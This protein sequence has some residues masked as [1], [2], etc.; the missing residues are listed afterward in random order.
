MQINSLGTLRKNRLKNCPFK[1]DRKLQEA[2]GRYDF[3][4]DENNKLIAVK[5]VDNKV[6][7]L[8]SSFVG[9][10]PLGSVKRWNAAEKRKVDVP[11]PKIVQQYN[12]HMGVSI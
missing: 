7:T 8:A 1:D 12:K 2:K 3:W 10:Q 11:C 9:V 4:Y 6:V 5:W